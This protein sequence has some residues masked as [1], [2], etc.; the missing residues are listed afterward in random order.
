[1]EKSIGDIISTDEIIFAPI[2]QAFQMP[3]CNKSVI[4]EI[5]EDLTL[6]DYLPEIRR[7]LR[8]TPVVSIPSQYV[9]G[10]MAEFSG[11]VNWNILYVCGEGTLSE[12]TFSSPY[13]VSVDFDGTDAE[14]TV[15][16]I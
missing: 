6:P 1:M 14:E 10:S 8:V 5:S 3:V 11:N 12:A 9:N 2:S 7:L 15:A 13:E 4:T 16:F